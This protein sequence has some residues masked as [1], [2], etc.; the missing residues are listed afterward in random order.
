MA[1]RKNFPHKPPDDFSDFT[2]EE[3]IANSFWSDIATST[4]RV[5]SSGYDI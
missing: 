2:D 4:R 3:Y 5:A 1:M